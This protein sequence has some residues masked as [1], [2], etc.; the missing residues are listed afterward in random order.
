VRATRASVTLRLAAPADI[1]AV[2]IMLREAFG[3]Y[4]AAFDRLG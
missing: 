4:P 1:A 3:S 2:D